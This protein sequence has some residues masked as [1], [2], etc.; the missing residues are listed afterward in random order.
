MICILKVIDGPAQ[1]AQLWISRNQCLVIGRMSTADFSIPEDPHLSRNHLFVES[2]EE[3]FRVRD[4]GSSNGT[5]VNNAPVSTVELC[6][7]DLIRAGKSVFQ[8]TLK[9]EILK[10]QPVPS[11]VAVQTQIPSRSVFQR[12]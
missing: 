5:F 9:D 8:V 6:T 11:D 3:S 1:G 12:G 10:P 2:G 4:A 7:G